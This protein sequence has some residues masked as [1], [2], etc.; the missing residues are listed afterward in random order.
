M[1]LLMMRRIGWDGQEK[2][3]RKTIDDDDD[4]DTNC[5]LRVDSTL[6]EMPCKSSSST[7]GAA[8]YDR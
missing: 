5:V 1:I 3:V 8:I 2:C 7:F 4:N 6:S